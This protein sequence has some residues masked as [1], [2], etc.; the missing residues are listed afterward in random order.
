MID[1]GAGKKIEAWWLALAAILAVAAFFRFYDLGKCAFRGDTILLWN[2]ALR[3]VPPGLLLTQWFEVSGAAGQMP[4]PAF[5]MQQFLSLAG[6]PLTPFWVRFPFAFFGLLA[7]SAAF[8]GGRKLFGAAFGLVIAALL[9]V[10]SFHI[11][12]AR[13]S[14]FYSTLIFGYFLYF[15]CGAAITDRLLTGQALKAGDLAILA[16]ALFFTAYSQITGLLLCA[17]AAGLFF[18]L[19]FF[20]QRQTPVF[21]RNMVS[22]T[23]VHAVLLAPVAIAS[24]GLRPLLSQ[25]GANRDQA[26]QVA[27]MSGSNLLRGVTEALEQFSWG[28]TGPRIVLLLLVLGGAIFAFIRNRE[29]RGLWLLYFILAEIV[30][31]SISRSAAGANYEARYMSGFFPFFLAALTYGLLYFPKAVF[32][33]RLPRRTAR[34]IAGAFCAAGLGACLYPAYLQ[35][36]LTGAPAPYYDLVRWTDSNLPKGTPI[37]ADRWF[38]PWN[39]LKA[40]PTT[41]VF[42]TFTVPNE[43]QEAYIKNRWRETAKDFFARFPDAAYLEVAKSYWQVPEIGPW[44]WPRQYFA[45]HVAITNEAGLK[46]RYL[47]LA[48]R[49]DFYAANSNRVV[50]ELFYNTPEDVVN[51]ARAAG[52]KVI[53]LYGEGWS[54][55]K[56]Q[57]YRDWRVLESSASADLYN[58]TMAPVTAE[59]V[60]RAVAISGSKKIKASNGSEKTF[61]IDQLV[62]WNIGR[63][64]L[65][66]GLNKLALADALWSMG[67]APLLVD[68]FDVSVVPAVAEA[69]SPQVQATP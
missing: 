34:G 25:I 53:G 28:W 10:N 47:G 7:V 23:V 49:G 6:W 55:T 62:E 21:K 44:E 9:A 11:A 63:L 45:R 35:T 27:A 69:R 50:V 59:V 61:I 41:N 37:L 17:A 3:K 67:K 20:R 60:L 64:T 52:R 24:W 4:M 16:A 15:W 42:F 14:Y 68:G 19:L 46:L 39:E 8:F 26:A 40:H 36:Q 30:L 5:L 2:M 48:N 54:Y 32:G 38:E 33:D 13:E 12:T 65:A 43:P 66:P 1:R 56:T 18:G 22:L 31:F 51:K 29:F 57:D 58:L